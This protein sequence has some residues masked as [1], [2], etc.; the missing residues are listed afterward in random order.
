MKGKKQYAGGGYI[1][2][3]VESFTP[4]QLAGIGSVVVTYNY[5]ERRLH[6]LF[7]DFVSYPGKPSITK[8]LAGRCTA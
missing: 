3:V 8:N 1:L 2:P 4:R 7:G 6:E 5:L